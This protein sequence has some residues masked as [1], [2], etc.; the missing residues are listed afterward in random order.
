MTEWTRTPVFGLALTLVSYALALALHRRVRWIHP[1]FPTCGGILLVLWATGVPT[2]AYDRGG[3]VLAGLLGP[4]TLAFGVP[5]FKQARALRRSLPALGIAVL[6]G[7]V[8]GM[9]T[10]VATAAL[11][12]APREVVMSALPKSVTTPIAMEVSRQLHGVPELS[13]AMALLAGT[14][15]ALFGPGLLRLARIRHELAH[16]AAMGTSSHAFGT[17]RALRD[18]E[19]QGSTAALAMALAG[20]ATA[21]LATTVPPLARAWDH[22]HPAPR[23]EGGGG[24]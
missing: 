3:D 14:L 1:L 16:G 9:I 24:R 10:A 4:A 7:A 15:G 6:A 21:L 2:E 5:L 19:R 22:F 17:A 8:V 13:A 20:I 18:G 11:L 12:G 23:V